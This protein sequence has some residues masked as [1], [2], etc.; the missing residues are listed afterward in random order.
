MPRPKKENKIEKGVTAFPVHNEN[1]YLKELVVPKGNKTLVVG[2]GKD[3]AFVE[4]Q[5]GEVKGVYLATRT[6]VDKEEFVKLYR[7]HI[8]SLFNLSPSGIKV[9]GYVMSALRISEDRVVFN[10]ADCQKF[11]GYK[12]RKPVYI[13]LSELLDNNFIART[14]N[15]YMYFINPSIFFN[16]NRFT[17]IKEF[18]VED[19]KE[20]LSGDWSDFHKNEKIS[21][22]NEGG[23]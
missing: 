9:F 17:V 21:N 20:L 19:N 4:Q 7:S 18:H 22:D 2:G 10:V 23:E 12:S 6:R 13:G 3:W 1:P 16:G 11:T 14:E 5:T 8:T 15:T